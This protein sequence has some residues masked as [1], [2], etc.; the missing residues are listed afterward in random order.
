MARA[1][2]SRW[3]DPAPLMTV[4]SPILTMELLLLVLLLFGMA[5]KAGKK[6]KNQSK[7]SD[8]NK[9][10][11][12]RQAYANDNIAAALQHLADDRKR[13]GKDKVSLRRAAQLYNVPTSTL[14][15]HYMDPTLLGRCCGPQPAIPREAEERLVEIALKHWKNGMALNNDQMKWFILQAV[16]HV[17]DMQRSR[18]A[19]RWLKKGTVKYSWYRRFLARH[20]QLSER[21]VDNLDPKRWK[22]SVEDIKSLYDILDRYRVLYPGLTPG[23]IANLDE[24][25]LT[26]DRRKKVCLAKTGAR[27][28][29]TLINDNRFSMTCLPCIFADGTSLPPHFIVKGKQK[30]RW[31]SSDEYIEALSGTVFEHAQVTPQE[32]AWMTT[33][34]F[35]QWFES[36][37][38]MYTADRRSESTPM[39]LVLDNFSGHVHPDVLDVAAENNVI[40]IGLPPHSTHITQPLDVGIMR[41]LK[42]NWTRALEVEKAKN[43]FHSID[44]RGVIE[45]LCK[46]SASTFG[47]DNTTG[48]P[49]SAWSKTFTKANVVSSFCKTGIWPVNFNAVEDEVYRNDKFTD[50]T[51]SAD[52]NTPSSSHGNASSVG[53]SHA[54]PPPFDDATPVELEWE[55]QVV[56]L[57]RQIE[58]LQD[59]IDSSRTS[60]KAALR[61]GVSLSAILSMP[62]PPDS[63]QRSTNRE[64]APTSAL[65][66]TAIQE[67]NLRRAKQ[68]L[69]I[70]RQDIQ[71]SIH[72]A[73]T[74]MRVA[75]RQATKHTN[76][77]GRAAAAAEK[78]ARATEEAL[79]KAQ[80]AFSR[81]RS[82]AA[83]Q[84]ALEKALQSATTHADKASSSSMLAQQFLA[85]AAHAEA[86]MVD[87]ETELKLLQEEASRDGAEE[88]EPAVDDPRDE[89]DAVD[90]GDEL[91]EE[92]DGDLQPAAADTHSANARASLARATAAKTQLSS[93]ITPTQGDIPT[94]IAPGNVPQETETEI[95]A[96]PAAET[97]MSSVGL[98]LETATTDPNAAPAP[99]EEAI[100]DING[101]DTPF[102]I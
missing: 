48:A 95:P 6:R 81:G 4:S 102:L 92:P 29:H 54:A 100:L 86:M 11:P 30:P 97:Q 93:L 59:K 66:L 78:Q 51:P 18:S 41:I 8:S 44:A 99:A 39:L 79:S 70:R 53:S 58:T 20:P 88:S 22:V 47:V 73:K 34:I 85:Q 2:A 45:L 38:L 16:L 26:P 63:T 77:A 37:F 43:Q 5:Y 57:K 31:C 36:Q 52:E 83:S 21:V 75:T 19:K 9:R 90:S 61:E 60:R 98:L 74:A 3:Y 33:E 80:Q 15:R 89:D 46:P 62:P 67:R 27:R 32:N 71:T 55:R 1:Y 68:E 65:V 12:Y 56:D 82:T 96:A 23:H 101:P 84:K 25:G 17:P 64:R 28:T 87:H 40:L 35:K 94:D 10:G 7:P 69:R 76:A 50:A 42:T 72:E 91:D 49:H 14:Q 13:K 24:T